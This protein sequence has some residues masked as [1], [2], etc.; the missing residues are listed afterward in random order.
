MPITEAKPMDEGVKSFL[1]A[2]PEEQKK[3]DSYALVEMMQDVTGKPPRMWGSSMVGFGE[4][5]YEYSS[6]HQGDCFVVGFAPRKTALTIYLTCD[7]EADLGAFLKMLGK[8]KTGKGCLYVKRLAEID[9]A[10]LRRM[11]ETV[12][13]KSSTLAAVKDKGAKSKRAKPS[14]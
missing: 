12:A 10:V 14:F 2:I 4:Y 3:A 8:F 1:D 13:Q 11:I 7:I 9:L 6:G 5:H